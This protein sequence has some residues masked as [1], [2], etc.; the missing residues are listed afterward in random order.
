M[1]EASIVLSLLDTLSDRCRQ[2]G[3]RSIE[4]VRLRIGMASGILPEAVTFAFEA[5]KHDTLAENAELVL[6]IVPLGGFCNSCRNDF[7][8]SETYVLNCPLCGSDSFTIRK[9]YELD[10]VEMEVN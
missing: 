9:G 4:S 2:E 1:H 8:V 5:A 7:E 6:D 3:Y 10:I